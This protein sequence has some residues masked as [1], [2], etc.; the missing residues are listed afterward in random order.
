MCGDVHGQFFDLCNIFEIN[1]DPSDENPYLFNGEFK[2][3]KPE[4]QKTLN[5]H[6]F[7]FFF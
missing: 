1:G 4:N 3:Q 6:E 7:R 2:T 5:T